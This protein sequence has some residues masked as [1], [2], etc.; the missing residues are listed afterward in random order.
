MMMRNQLLKKS[1]KLKQTLFHYQQVLQKLKADQAS[2]YAAY[3]SQLTD[4]EAEL[5][6]RARK[7]EED[8]QRTFDEDEAKMKKKLRFI[9]KTMLATTDPKSRAELY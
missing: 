6:Q 7:D 8:A 3:K 1:K 2:K 4:E 9:A 5:V